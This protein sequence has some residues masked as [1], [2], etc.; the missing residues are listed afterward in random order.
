MSFLLNRR[1][2]LKSFVSY[3]FTLYSLSACPTARVT[4]GWEGR[5]NAILTEPASS[6]TNRLK[7]RRLPLVGCTLGWAALASDT[8]SYPW[9]APFNVCT[10]FFMGSPDTLE[11]P[12]HSSLLIGLDYLCTLIHII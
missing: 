11:P 9:R 8:K 2:H 3:S 1:A 7:T 5:D 10:H 4:R 12:S 6:H